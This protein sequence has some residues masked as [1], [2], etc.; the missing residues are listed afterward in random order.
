MNTGSTTYTASL[1]FTS[2]SRRASDYSNTLVSKNT[3]IFM[4][5]YTM[6]LF[7]AASAQDG[8]YIYSLLKLYSRYD[9]VHDYTQSVQNKSYN[10]CKKIAS[11]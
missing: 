4:K 9:K 5:T 7:P 2:M 10:V 8:T 1:S 3:Y 11:K 6:S